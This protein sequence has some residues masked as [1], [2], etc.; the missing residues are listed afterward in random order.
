MYLDVCESVFALFVCPA[1]ISD[2][3]PVP[4]NRRELMLSHSY[5]HCA[6]QFLNRVIC[7]ITRMTGYS[8][9]T[10]STVNVQ[11]IYTSPTCIFPSVV[12]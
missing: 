9:V 10:N 5:L 2:S 6:F 1:G 4:H 12:T 7:L 11:Y 3:F 8:D